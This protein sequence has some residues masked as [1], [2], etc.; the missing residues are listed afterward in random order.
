MAVPNERERSLFVSEQ[1]FAIENNH[2]KFMPGHNRLREHEGMYCARKLIGVGQLRG[3]RDDGH[4]GAAVAF[5]WFEQNRKIGDRAEVLGGVKNARPNGRK[6]S[7]CEEELREGFVAGDTRGAGGVHAEIGTDDEPYFAADLQPAAKAGAGLGCP[8]PAAARGHFA[9]TLDLDGFVHDVR[10]TILDFARA[11][12]EEKRMA[13][14]PI[15]TLPTEVAARLEGFA[16]NLMTRLGENLV[17]IFLYGGVARGSFN[18]GSSNVNLMVVLRG[19]TVGALTDI[20]AALPRKAD[21]NLSLMTVTEGDLAECV[22]VFAIK[23]FDIKT[24]HLLLCGR[25]VLSTLVITQERLVRQARREL[26]NLKLRM[27]HAFV[28]TEEEDGRLAATLERAMKTVRV[29][30]DVLA[31][32]QETARAAELLRSSLPILEDRLAGPPAETRCGEFLQKL[33]AAIQ[34]LGPV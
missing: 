7:L 30:A 27:R 19:A 28:F 20:R 11:G 21:A 5:V 34:A 12:E 10:F 32:I 4:A 33:D 29:N 2:A 16:K 8:R 31:N 3:L 9:K 14:P 26:V 23:F 6:A 18:E 25:D 13:I 15:E 22:E 1:R 17:G 24:H